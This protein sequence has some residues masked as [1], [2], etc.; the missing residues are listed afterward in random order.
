MDKVVIIGGGMHANVLVD[1]ISYIPEVELIGYINVKETSINAK[2]LGNDNKIKYLKKQGAEYFIVGIG[3]NKTRK[4]LF[5]KAIREGIKPYTIISP[6]TYI[7]ETADIGKGCVIMP[8]VTIQTGVKIGENCIINTNS[9]IDHDCLIGSHTHI[10]PGVTLS[11][12]VE[13]GLETLLG[14]GAIAINDINIGENCII[15]AGTVVIRDLPKNSKVAG[16][17]AQNIK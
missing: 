13:I 17:P 9:S 6:H 8:G 1:V 15:G 12:S 7:S 10:A 4:R 14:T 2:F 16:V 11:G 5:E 3:N